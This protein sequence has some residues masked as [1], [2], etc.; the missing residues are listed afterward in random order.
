M[1]NTTSLVFGNGVLK[2]G[3]V[4]DDGFIDVEQVGITIPGQY[5]NLNDAINP[6]LGDD[7]S[8]LGETP[9]N[10]T[11]TI[12]Y[13]VGGGV[14]SNLQSN[15]IDT[16]VNGVKISGGG[17]IS[18]LSVLNGT[19]ARGGKNQESVDEIREKARAFFTTQNLSLIHI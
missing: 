16:I 4:V 18:S 6:L 8:T 19:P 11:L 15:T 12:T 13:R 17:E 7:Y 2:N 14:N 9:N 5:G 3:Q 10:T 1:N